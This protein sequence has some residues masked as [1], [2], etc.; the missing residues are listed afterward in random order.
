MENN[1]ESREEKIIG[2]VLN[3]SYF[4]C[5]VSI[6]IFLWD[7]IQPESFFGFVFFVLVWVIMNKIAA[8]PFGIITA[9]IIAWFDNKR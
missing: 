5:W 2:I 8:I 4:A 9:W 3:L 1:V 6:G 7:K